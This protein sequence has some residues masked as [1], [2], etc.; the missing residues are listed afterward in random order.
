MGKFDIPPCQ[1]ADQKESG[2]VSIADLEKALK[3]EGVVD[4][5]TRTRVNDYVRAHQAEIEKDPNL[6][7]RHE[8]VRNLDLSKITD[9]SF[10]HPAIGTCP[11]LE[12]YLKPKLS[13]PKL[14]ILGITDRVSY[15]QYG[16]SGWSTINK[17][18]DEGLAKKNGA[19]VLNTT[20]PKITT[21]LRLPNLEEL[22]LDEIF[23]ISDIAEC[24]ELNRK[25]AEGSVSFLEE[26]QQ[27]AKARLGTNEEF[28]FNFKPSVNHTL[29]FEC[30]ANPYPSGKPDLNNLKTGEVKFKYKGFNFALAEYVQD[31]EED[32]A[33]EDLPDNTLHLQRCAVLALLFIDGLPY[34]ECTKIPAT[35]RVYDDKG[36]PIRKLS[37]DK[38]FVSKTSCQSWRKWIGL[39][40]V[41][42]DNNEEWI[43]LVKKEK[44]KTRK[45]IE[46]LMGKKE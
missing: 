17:D 18:L 26:I 5:E 39:Q 27:R 37:S 3:T 10:E 34:R 12:A 41:V 23:E 31:N 29:C 9:Y 33:L 42:V 32:A 40:D 2:S 35:N 44:E 19:F 45:M 16:R 24:I 11:K 21:G 20:V 46:E 6:D 25:M 15:D 7:P 28:K 14:G 43:S 36:M 13:D 1:T 8:M 30:V 22:S 38:Y 4:E